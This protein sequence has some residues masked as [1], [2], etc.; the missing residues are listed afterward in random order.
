VRRF[1]IY[2][3][4]QWKID[5]VRKY[6]SGKILENIC[7]KSDENTMQFYDKPPTEDTKNRS[8]FPVEIRKI[9]Y[10]KR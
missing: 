10:I 2:S 6:L 1:S 9:K 8:E 5:G 4:L 7:L 3:V